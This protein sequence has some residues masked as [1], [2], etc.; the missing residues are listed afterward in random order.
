MKLKISNLGPI[1]SM[2]IDMAKPFILFAGD[3]GTGKTYAATFLYVL[4]QHLRIWNILSDY[5][6]E[7]V[8]LYLSDSLKYCGCF[9]NAPNICK[10]VDLSTIIAPKSHLTT[11]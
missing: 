4:I 6:F 7:K 9:I 10:I 5:Q 1:D 3:N 2:I 8:R 11:T